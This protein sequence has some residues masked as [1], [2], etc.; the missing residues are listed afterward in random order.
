MKFIKKLISIVLSL[1]LIG[2]VLLLW[3]G[4]QDVLDWYVLRSYTPPAEVAQLA[5]STTMTDYGKRIFYVNHPYIA[6]AGTINTECGHE[7]SIVIG[8]YTTTGGIFIYNVTDPRLN[9]IKEV[10]AGHEMLHAA[11]FRLSFK[12]RQEVD[13]LTD[14]AYKM[15]T[16]QQI[17]ENVEN[18]RKQDPSVVPNELHSILATEVANLPPKLEEYYKKY[19]NNRL[20]IVAF[21][22]HYQEEFNSRQQKVADFDKQLDQLKIDI[23]QARENLSNKMNELKTEK[24]KL[25]SLLENNQ[26]AIYNQGVPGFNAKVNL[27]NSLVKQTDSQINEYNDIVTERNKITVEV[28]DLAQSIDS[29]PQSF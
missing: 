8:C 27:Y 29:R 6:P 11:Y 12:K 13:S 5:K 9:G 14:Q 16:D 17:R 1:A 23:D 21:S 20:A 3:I 19:F 7:S 18:Y 22:D 24:S 2:A 15:I 28:K 10:T 26:I 25:D 4:R